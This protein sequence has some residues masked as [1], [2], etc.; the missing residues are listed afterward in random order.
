M[1]V[2]IRAVEGRSAY[3]DPQCKHPIPHDKWIT[4]PETT[5]LRRLIDIHGDVEEHS[6]AASAPEAPPAPEP[7][8]AA[9][10]APVETATQ[11]LRAASAAAA[12]S[13]G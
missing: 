3:L 7:P 13:A 10:A 8:A 11:A 5:H 9:P 2:T 12:A 4:V 1:I 6:A